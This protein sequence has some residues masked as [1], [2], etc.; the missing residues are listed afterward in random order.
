MIT[1]TIFAIV[2]VLA[3]TLMSN[4]LKSMRKIQAQVFLYTEAQNVMDQVAR[5]V[6]G[7][8][9]DYE[10]YYDRYVENESAAPGWDTP[11][12]GYYA[13]SFYHPGD[14]GY[15]A[16][17]PYDDEGIVGYGGLCADGVSAYPND[18]PAEEYALAGTPDDISGSHPFNNIEFYPGSPYVADQ[19][20]MNAF[21]ESDTVGECASFDLNLMEELILIN[22]AGDERFIF[23]LEMFDMDSNDYYLSKVHML[24]SDTTGNGISDSWACHGKYDCEETGLIGQPV[25]DPMDLTDTDN[26]FDVKDQND[27]QPI[28]SSN[29]TV[30]EF[31]IYI[32]PAENPFLAYEE[33]D[34]QIQPHVTL[35]LTV[36]LSEKYSQGILGEVP[37]VTIQRT[38]S[39][40]VYNAV[41]SY[42]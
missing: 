16:S 10:A 32:A 1:M 40:G 12:Y 11:T 15:D 4:S 29:L 26:L 24:G 30:K 28:T 20:T 41:K 23:L 6:E 9:V 37:E 38:I 27:F 36:S 8:T 35:L 2:A 19:S 18:C 34:M 42:E 25:P 21:C 7:N 3:F 31:F 13:K 17:G 14:D 39:S 22:A 33:V 5:V